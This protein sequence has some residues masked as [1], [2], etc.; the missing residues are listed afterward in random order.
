MNRKKPLNYFER[1]KKLLHPKR[2]RHYFLPDY[3]YYCGERWGERGA[4]TSGSLVLTLY[5]AFCVM[6]P[7]YFYLDPVPI[8]S[9][10]D[11]ERVVAAMIFGFVLPL[12]LCLLRYRKERRAALM[13]HYRRSEWLKGIPVWFV[14]LGWFPLAI[15]EMW[16]LDALEWI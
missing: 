6:L 12:V 1:Q 7:L 3:W 14:S 2:Y 9:L 11:N 16:L 8:L 4:R 5:W 13:K 15:L 10:S